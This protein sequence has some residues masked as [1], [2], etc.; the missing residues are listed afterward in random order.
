[1]AIAL[2]WLVSGSAACFYD[3]ALLAAG[4]T[5]VLAGVAAALTTPTDALRR[6]LIARNVGIEPFFDHLV[7]RAATT[8]SNRP[9][10][11]AVLTKLLGRS[12]GEPHAAELAG[13]LG[14]C[15]RA[16]FAA[17]PRLVDEL[18]LRTGPLRELWEAHGPGLLAGVVR[19]TDRRLAVE[20][21]TVVAVQPFGGAGGRSYPPYNALTIEAVLTNPLA[22]LPETVRLAWLVAS[23]NGDLP[24]FVESLAPGTRTDETQRLI[25]LAVLPAVLEAAADVEVVR[26]STELLATAAAAWNAPLVEGPRTVELLA[27]WW[28]FTK[29]SGTPWP[30]ALAGLQRLLGE[31]SSN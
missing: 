29:T 27:G 30:I 8:E 11:D 5:P 1:M 13:L 3:V 12:R 20:A 31:S 7:P 15:E 17:F 24:D 4:R 21:A 18:A 26:P 6:F 25:Q 16:Y 2:S 28:E 23:L 19:R 22:Q 14:D 10:A 9:L